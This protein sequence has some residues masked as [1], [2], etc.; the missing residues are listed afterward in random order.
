MIASLISK[1]EL[2]DKFL[3]F[4]YLQIQN[5]N[6]YLKDKFPNALDV[7]SLSF[8]IVSNIF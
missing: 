4:H 2:H 6:I 5:L 7:I 8:S 3:S 1:I